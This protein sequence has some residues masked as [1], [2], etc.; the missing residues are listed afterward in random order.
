VN[1]IKVT[2]VDFGSQNLSVLL[3]A[4]M[5]AQAAEKVITKLAMEEKRK[6][7]GQ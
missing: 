6:G 7:D 3:V 4:R 1:E 2:V 5:L